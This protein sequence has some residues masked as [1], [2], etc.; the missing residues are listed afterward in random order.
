MS[1]SVILGFECE[2]F[3]PVSKIVQVMYLKF[4]MEDNTIEILH[5]QRK[6]AFLARIFYP[7]ITFTDLFIG[8]SVTM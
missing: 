2:W 4:F 5:S 3:D 6:G 7:D 1:S 8:N